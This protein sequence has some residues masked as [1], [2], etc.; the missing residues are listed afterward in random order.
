[1]SVAPRRTTSKT[2][3]APLTAAEGSMFHMEEPDGLPQGGGLADVGYKV[4]RVQAGPETMQPP[5]R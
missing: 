4:L 5:G 2:F 1:M 3:T